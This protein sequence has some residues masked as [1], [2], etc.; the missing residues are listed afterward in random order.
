MAISPANQCLGAERDGVNVVGFG[1]LE[2]GT[3]G[4]ACTWYSKGDALESDIRLNKANPAWTLHS[5]SSGCQGRFG[6]EAVATHEFGHAFGLAHVSEAGHAA[7]TMS[8]AIA[9]CDAS[10]ATLGL[11]DVRGLRAKY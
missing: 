11:G 5:E 4:L 7:L 2:A 8:T 6:V 1:D 10:A 9:P 3:L